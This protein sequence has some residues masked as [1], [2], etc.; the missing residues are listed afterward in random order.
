MNL[1]TDTARV[2]ERCFSAEERRLL[3]TDARFAKAVK[4][5][6]SLADL[7]H[8]VSLGVNVL[9]RN[10]YLPRRSERCASSPFGNLTGNHFPMVMETVRTE[11]ARAAQ[12]EN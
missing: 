3:D 8:V 11:E 4:A 5:M 12:L 6:H 7:D 1:L 10:G 2:L 9:E